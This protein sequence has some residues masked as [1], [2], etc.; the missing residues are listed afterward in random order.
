MAL[1]ER[2]SLQVRSLG[3]RTELNAAGVYAAY[4]GGLRK[5]S[6]PQSSMPLANGELQPESN[7][8]GAGPKA[9][10]RRSI[11]HSAVPVVSR[12]LVQSRSS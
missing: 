11:T 5:C 2:I 8:G 12:M 7:T 1:H 4:G 9:V 3:I 6:F 10:P